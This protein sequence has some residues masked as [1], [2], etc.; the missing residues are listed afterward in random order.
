VRLP[1]HAPPPRF[2]ILSGD[3]ERAALK[4][5]HNLAWIEAKAR[6]FDAPTTLLRVVGGTRLEIAAFRDG[7]PL[8]ASAATPESK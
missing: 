1:H 5:E 4:Q 2:V 7:V 6:S 8:R 3:T